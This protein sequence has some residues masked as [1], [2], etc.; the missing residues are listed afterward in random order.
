MKKIIPLALA[1]VVI[2]AKCNKE[3]VS[4]P[5]LPPAT[6]EGKNTVG[7]TINGEV[8]VPYAKCAAFTNPCREI[9]VRYGAAGGASPNGIAFSFFRIK[10]DRESSL[11]ISSPFATI[12][13]PGEKV[14]SIGVTFLSESLNGNNG[15]FRGPLS[16]SKFI[17]TKIDHQNQ[18]ISG[19]FEFI[20]LEQNGSGNTITL[21][22]G[23]FDFKFNA[24]K[25][26]N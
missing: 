10:N 25:C 5:T 11:I 13:S 8:W 23:R 9:S 4:N 16:G 1:I 18:I 21:N 17:I 22:N 12:T 15:Y 3:S 14:D 26:S 2:A 19:E 7:F 6:Q 20:L 24:C